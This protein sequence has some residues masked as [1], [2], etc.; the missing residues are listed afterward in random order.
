MCFNIHAL[1]DHPFSRGTWLSVVEYVSLVVV[2]RPVYSWD[3]CLYVYR[4]P[5][6]IYPIKM[7]NDECTLA[8]RARCR[9]VSFTNC[10]LS[11]CLKVGVYFSV[12]LPLWPHVYASARSVTLLRLVV[13]VRPII[14]NFTLFYRSRIRTSRFQTT[15]PAWLWI[16]FQSHR[17]N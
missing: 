2:S 15:L 14:T 1:L 10:I 12:T 6:C 17:T 5:W 16:G 13:S 3:Y 7:L 8:S 11:A 4:F 9:H